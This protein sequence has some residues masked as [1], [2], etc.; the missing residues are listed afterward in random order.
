[1]M[2]NV[3]RRKRTSTTNAE[4]HN[5]ICCSRVR[6]MA[7]L[8]EATVKDVTAIFFFLS[9]SIFDCWLAREEVS[10]PKGD[11]QLVHARASLIPVA[12]LSFVSSNTDQF[13]SERPDMLRDVDISLAI[14]QSFKPVEAIRFNG[15]RP[16]EP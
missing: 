3:A 10:T 11:R 9:V 2:F 14:N 5:S 12:H 13:A 15:M 6:G 8:Y 4:R 7:F 16:P 1:M